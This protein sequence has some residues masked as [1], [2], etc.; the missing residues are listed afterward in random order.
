[1]A[2]VE[3]GVI[4]ADLFFFYLD[5]AGV[6][7]LCLEERGVF[8][9]PLFIPFMS[10]RSCIGIPVL[11]PCRI[12]PVRSTFLLCRLNPHLK[13]THMQLQLC[14]LTVRRSPDT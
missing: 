3:R 11:Y 8:K 5:L 7:R 9:Q 12:P 14:P 10:Q 1:M 2:G 13:Q 6:R 4:R